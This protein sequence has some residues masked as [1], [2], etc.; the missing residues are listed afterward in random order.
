M[1]NFTPSAYEG[2][3]LGDLRS[4][5]HKPSEMAFSFT[6]S[7]LRAVRLMASTAEDPDPHG[8]APQVPGADA[9]AAGEDMDI[10]RDY[11]NLDALQAFPGDQHWWLF[12]P[13]P[14]NLGRRECFD[15]WVTA[16]T[17]MLEIE[18]QIV[19]EWPDLQPGNPN[20]RIVFAN[21]LAF[22][23]FTTPVTTESNAFVVKAEADEPNDQVQHSVILL[24]LRS[25]VPHHGLM[26]STPLRAFVVDTQSVVQEIF[27]SIDFQQRCD[28]TPCPIEHNG[29]IVA[30]WDHE[31]PLRLFD[32]DYVHV[33]AATQLESIR[34]ITADQTGR[35]IPSLEELPA[36]FQQR[37]VTQMADRAEVDELV[38]LACRAQ[39]AFTSWARDIYDFTH[40]HQLRRSALAVFLIE[41]DQ[42]VFM[43]FFAP[44]PL[45]VF[46]LYY[47]IVQYMLDDEEQN[48]QFVSIDHAD[49]A[50]LDPQAQ[51][52][53]LRRADR[54][55]FY[56]FEVACLVELRLASTARGSER[57]QTVEYKSRFL[58]RQISQEDLYASVNIDDL[59][60]QEDCLT[61][62]DGRVQ[63]GSSRL[64][65]QEGSFVQI[66]VGEDT[67][68]SNDSQIADMDSC[69]LPSMTSRIVEPSQPVE[70]Q[71]E[72]SLRPVDS[73]HVSRSH[74]ATCWFGWMGLL[75]I[76]FAKRATLPILLV[77][78]M[79]LIGVER[80]GEA[81]HPGPAIWIGTTNPSGLRGKEESYFTLPQ[82]LWG[83][84]ETHLT[85]LNQRD[86]NGVIYRLGRSYNR[87]L[88]IHHGHPVAP[89]SA[90]SS[91]GTWAGV[92]MIKDLP[93]RPLH[94]PWPHS[95]PTLGRVQL[96]QTWCG[97]FQMTGAN[98]YYGWPQSPTWPR[99]KEATESLLNHLTKELVLS[100]T[101]PR[102]IT[103]PAPHGGVIFA[104][105]MV[106]NTGIYSVL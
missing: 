52:L 19:R 22:D 2:F 6:E 102:F 76:F 25:W 32:G 60:Q 68:A 105:K 66:F 24:S 30:P 46:Q 51:Y 45:D 15:L 50:F 10:D 42:V 27:E 48:W 98:L 36:E 75:I 96:F 57:L 93:C 1:S 63:S 59:C 106:K 70:L 91:T 86:A 12:R 84:V 16:A 11:D 20:W 83:V 67:S 81:Q 55:E 43:R 82:G 103:E 39:Q 33:H 92:S 65:L 34:A 3:G 21:N 99:A 17:T 4:L 8:V 95:E 72:E 104:L 18:M 79:L 94:I 61:V 58:P 26:A 5:A 44:L 101:G 87:S 100:R 40:M 90:R 71:H 64:L 49:S 80:F 28:G 56:D 9:P 74:T 41:A 29:Y 7:F 37:V 53:G 97:P 69:L 13:D 38:L 62:V 88:Q 73:E 78:Y 85:V 31:H 54:Q 14:H 77:A 35:G 89:R 23:A 47:S